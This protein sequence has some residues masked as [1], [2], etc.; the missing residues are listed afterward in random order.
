MTPMARHPTR[1]P[2]AFVGLFALLAAAL[3]SAG[4]AG[5][6]GADSV[7]V[8][9]LTWTELRDALAAGRSTLIIPVGGVEQNGPHMAL[10]KH[11]LRAH[12]LAARI[13]A[14][15]GN[16]LVA[17]VVGYV[18]EG[19][20]SPPTEHM[21]FPGTISVPE[22][23]FKAVIDATARSYRQHGFRDIVIVGDSGNY[24]AALKA[25]AD[26]L[27]RDWA[28]S[29]ARAHYVGAYYD[30]VQGAYV[31]ALHDRGLSDAQIGT[32]AAV[33]DTSL[34][35]ALVPGA[36]RPERFDLAAR[37]GRALGVQGDPR[38]ASAAL[39]Q[40]GVDLIVTR[41]VDAIRAAVAAPR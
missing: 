22:D 30:T 27:N 16:A 6:N 11:N 26:R 31:K 38:A 32:H 36:V 9:D 13:A 25:V 39:G 20:I 41:S 4:A 19:R 10:G 5:A 24:Q 37:E 34:L 18:P 7:Q 15:L 17:P 3:L 40:L 8:E 28:G 21:R 33:A 35:M 2:R 14:R 1:A 23:A 12:A 29:P